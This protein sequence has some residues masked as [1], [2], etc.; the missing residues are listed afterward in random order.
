M[1]SLFFLSLQCNTGTNNCDTIGISELKI[2][3]QGLPVVFVSFS[4][5]F[6][7]FVNKSF[8]AVHHTVSEFGYYMKGPK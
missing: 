3:T 4:V 8:L 7:H 5:S 6:V 1:M 2:V